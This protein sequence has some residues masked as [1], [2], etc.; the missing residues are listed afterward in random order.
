MASIAVLPVLIGLAVDYAIQLQ[1]RIGARGG[2]TAGAGRRARSGAPPAG[3][4]DRRDGR[5]RDRGRLRRARALAGADGARLRAAARRRH[6]DRV[7][8]RADLAAPRRSSRPRRGGSAAPRGAGRSPR[9]LGAR[10][11]RRC[12]APASWCA[13]NRLSRAVGRARRAAGAARCAG[14][15]SAGRGAC[16]R[17]ASAVALRAGPGHADAVE[18]DVQKLVPQDLPALRDLAGAAG[19]H[20]RRRRDRRRRSRGDEL[21]DP[22][23]VSW[24][25]ALPGGRCSGASATAPARGCGRA[26]LCPA[27]SLPDLFTTGGVE[28]GRSARS[29]RCWTP[30]PPT[31]RRA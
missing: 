8:L 12:A 24:M 13:A 21:T 20:G 7:R 26:E 29:T 1:S 11:R 9:R 6:R 28:R 2:G 15:A 19:V 25:T 23:V 31:S 16:W 4:A 22:T 5:G 17:S 10:S 14:R 30:C 18:S 27:F 3:R